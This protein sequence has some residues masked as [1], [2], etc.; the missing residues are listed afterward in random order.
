MVGSGT[1]AHYGK[2][3][4]FSLFSL[5]IDWLPPPFFPAI[6]FHFLHLQSK[7][8]HKFE[9]RGG[10]GGLHSGD[11]FERRLCRSYHQY[12]C[13]ARWVPISLVSHDPKR[14][15]KRACESSSFCSQLKTPQIGKYSFEP[16]A[17]EYQPIRLSR[18]EMGTDS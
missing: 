16:S 13:M 10:R 17:L 6:Y 18:G 9:L 7:H 11:C 2:C 8:K 15:E 4:A 5:D 12:H 14:R 3:C 1:L